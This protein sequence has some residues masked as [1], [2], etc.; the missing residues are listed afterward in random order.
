VKNASG[1]DIA[2]TVSAQSS[3]A[4]TYDYDG[5]V[6]RGAASAATPAPV[7]LVAIGLDTA[8]FVISTGTITRTTGITISAVAAL[9]RNYLNA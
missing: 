3:I 8:Q 2:G 5:N 7:T 4:F 1:T 6:Q 9:E